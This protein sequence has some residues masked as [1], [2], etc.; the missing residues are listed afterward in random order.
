MVLV[1][2]KESY[3]WIACSIKSKETLA[4]AQEIIIIQDREADIYEQFCLVPDERTHLLIRAKANRQHT[5]QSRLFEHL[6]GQQLQGQY[7][8]ILEGNKRRGIKKR[9]ATIEVHFSKVT[10]SRN[11]YND[12][13]LLPI[14]DLYA[15]E[16]REV[17]EGI[18]QPI[19]W[20]LLTTK[21][22]ESLDMALL[23]IEWYTAGLLKKCSV[24]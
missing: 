9:T 2:E 12:Q 23:C 24:S 4:A 10:T 6:A 15:I 20:R 3:K 18:E 11:Q 21:T 22:V 7:Q 17:T 13:S 16:A 19:L 14:K 5:N 8:V 1:I